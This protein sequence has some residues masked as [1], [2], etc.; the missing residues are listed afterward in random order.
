MQDNGAIAQ[1]TTTGVNFKIKSEFNDDLKELKKW[2][3]D[4]EGYPGNM[5]DLLAEVLEKAWPEVKKEVSQLKR[6]FAG[7]AEE[8]EFNDD[9]K[10]LKKWRKDVE[11]YKGSMDDLLAE[12]LEKAWPEVKKEVSQL[13][14][15]FA[16]L[17]EEEE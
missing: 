17:S 2:R 10:E 8:S 7:L 3:K 12:V 16:G 11:G 13:K 5:A 14:R 15:K 6:K 1:E 4:V 9:L